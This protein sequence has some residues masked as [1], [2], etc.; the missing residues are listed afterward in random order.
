[1]FVWKKRCR[2]HSLSNYPSIA[3][4]IKTIIDIHT[5]IFAYTFLH[6]QGSTSTYHHRIFH[7][8]SHSYIISEFVHVKI[9]SLRKMM[10]MRIV[11]IFIFSQHSYN[12]CTH[13]PVLYFKQLNY[14]E[15]TAYEHGIQ[16]FFKS[17]VKRCFGR[18]SLYLFCFNR[19]P[20][21]IPSPY[22][23]VRIKLTTNIYPKDVL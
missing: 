7:I 12:V 19:K 21:E 13:I 14:I 3:T 18:C 9:V 4:I 20:L 2:C 17:I 11:N 5:Y 15:N 16:Y 10:I 1:M 6:G 22:H 8:P 23:T